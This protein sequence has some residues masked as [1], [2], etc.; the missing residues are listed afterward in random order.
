MRTNSKT[1]TISTGISTGFGFET[2]PDK[3][4]LRKNRNMRRESL[5]GIYKSLKE[6]CVHERGYYGC[7]EVFS[8][9]N[10]ESNQLLMIKTLLNSLMTFQI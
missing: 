10:K 1:S 7:R 5:I 9:E 8:N 6:G 2:S 3:F 4:A